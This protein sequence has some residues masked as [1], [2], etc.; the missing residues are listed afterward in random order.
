MGYTVLRYER[1]ARFLSGK[2]TLVAV[3]PEPGLF[4]SKSELKQLKN[5]IGNGSTLIL[6][7]SSENLKEYNIGE[8]GIQ[9]PGF[10]DKNGGNGVYRSGKG[11]I[12]LLDNAGAY[13]NEGLRSY[14]SGIGFINIL[15]RLKNKIMLFDE[16]Y[17]GF[18]GF[19]I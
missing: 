15:D 14:T 7:C 1:S 5:W 4:N 17:H 8:L 16:Y 10:F 11:N 19:R 13:T 3:N 18:S 12:I 2:A 6:V 9:S